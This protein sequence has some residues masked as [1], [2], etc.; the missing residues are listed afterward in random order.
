M[1]TSR[2]RIYAVS[3]NA[4]PGTVRLVKATH[5]SHALRHVAADSLSVEVATQDQL[6]ELVSAG[7]TVETIQQEQAE[8]PTT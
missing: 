3:D 7:T 1:S 6:V 4:N 5:P 2:T 8:L